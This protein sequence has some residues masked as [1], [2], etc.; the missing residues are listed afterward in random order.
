MGDKL[1]VPAR[2]NHPSP[3]APNAPAWIRSLDAIH[4][5]ARRVAALH[6]LAI[7]SRILLALAFLPTGLVKLSGRRFTVADAEAHPVGA[8]FE[9]MYQAGIHWNFL[10]LGQ[11]GVATLLLVP[12][13]LYLVCWDW[14]RVSSILMLPEG[15]RI[16]APCSL[17]AVERVG[18]TLG[19]GS[20]L[21]LVMAPRD[22]GLFGVPASGALHDLTPLEAGITGVTRV[23]NE[24]FDAIAA[25]DLRAGISEYPAQLR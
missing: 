2:L 5:R 3:A 4:L 15:D 6:R 1:S 21:A 17:P 20:G 12:A 18:C 14:H 10:G 11:V 24:A 22:F 19:A 23:G 13:T 25:T 7:I 8:F 16:P 9:A